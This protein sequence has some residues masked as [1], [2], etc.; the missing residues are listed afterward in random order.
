[1]KWIGE[2]E[3]SSTFAGIMNNN[4]EYSVM[5]AFN[6][7]CCDNIRAVPAPIVQLK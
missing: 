2:Y 6:D 7:M 5:R 1:M 4:E 3:G